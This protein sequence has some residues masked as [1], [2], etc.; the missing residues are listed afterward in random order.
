MYQVL[1]EFIVKNAGFAHLLYWFNFPQK[2]QN[3]PSSN[4]QKYSTNADNRDK[5]WSQI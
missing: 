3:T 1:T 2:V 4:I 5:P